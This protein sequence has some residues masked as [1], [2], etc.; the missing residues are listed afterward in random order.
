M[1]FQAILNY[2]QVSS[3]NPFAF[4]GENLPVYLELL[5]NN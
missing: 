2:P 4:T 3:G 5:L 1:A